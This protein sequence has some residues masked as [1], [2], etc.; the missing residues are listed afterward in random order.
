MA[1]SGRNALSGRASANGI[2]VH[3]L[4]MRLCAWE[5]IS[6]GRM[7]GRMRVSHVRGALVDLGMIPSEELLALVYGAWF[8]KWRMETVVVDGE[9]HQEVVHDSPAATA[10][11]LNRRPLART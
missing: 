2:D 9:E 4:S 11:A 7:Q 5:P 8:G 10:R 3:A 6:L 1:R